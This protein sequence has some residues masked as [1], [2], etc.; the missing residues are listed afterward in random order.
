MRW[1]VLKLELK[2]T[3]KVSIEISTH[4]LV[5]LGILLS[6]IRVFWLNERSFKRRSETKLEG[7]GGGESC[8]QVAGELRVGEKEPKTEET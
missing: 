6:S 8:R 1:T 7:G 2:D 5:L 3:P 4:T